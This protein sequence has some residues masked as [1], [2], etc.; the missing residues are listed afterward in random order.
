M[1]RNR[2]FSQL[3]NENK[4]DVHASPTTYVAFKFVA[5]SVITTSSTFE[6]ITTD[7]YGTGFIRFVEIDDDNSG[8]PLSQYVQLNSS[9]GYTSLGGNSPG[10]KSV[11]ITVP[12]PAVAPPLVPGTTYWLVCDTVIPFEYSTITQN[13]YGTST[14]CKVRKGGG[15]WASCP[16]LF[17]KITY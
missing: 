17:M 1:Q 5:S 11:V 10:Y 14:E 13:N 4:Y 8:E 12:A 2:K 6:V 7:T 16:N 9:P 3:I 15:N